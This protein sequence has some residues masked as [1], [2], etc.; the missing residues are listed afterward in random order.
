MQQMVSMARIIA[1]RVDDMVDDMDGLLAAVAA[2]SPP[3]GGQAQAYLDA[4]RPQLRGYIDDV[5]VWSPQGA[6]LAHVSRGEGEAF[7]DE[8]LLRSAIRTRALA[9]DG[10]LRNRRGD[11]VLGFARPVLDARGEI[12]AVVG[13]SVRAR[14]LRRIVDPSGILPAHALVGLVDHDGLVVARS[15]DQERFVGQYAPVESIRRNFVAREGAADDV[16][17][18]GVRRLY[19]FTTPSR[20][21]W[22]AYVGFDGAAALAPTWARLVTVLVPGT[23]A[24]L[25]GVLLAALVGTHIA[26]ALGTLAR[27]AQR[28]SRGEA[29]GVSSVDGKDEIAVLARTLD[30]MAASLRERTAAVAESRE[31]LSRVTANV[32]VLIAHID[33]RQRIRFANAYHRDVFG[34]APQRLLGRSLR[35]LFPSATYNR[36]EAQVAEV[37][38][39]DPASFETTLDTVSGSRWFLVSCFPDYGDDQAVTG[40]YVVCQDITRRREA[41]DALKQSDAARRE[42]ERRIRLI[43][44]N[45]PAAITYVNR[46]E[47]YLFCNAAFSA[48]FERSVADLI[49]CRVADVLTP[50]VYASTRPHIEAVLRGEH[51]RFQRL[52]TRRGTPRHELVEYIP[53][54][55][56]AGE[57]SGFFALIQ[58]ITD[59]HDAQAQVEASE[60]RLRGMTES[61]PSLLCYID[62]A[63][64]YR[65]NSRYYEEWMGLPLAQI[66]GRHVREVVGEA[67]F[68]VDEPAMRRALAG[69]RVEFEIAHTDAQGTRYVRGT[70]V[71][72]VGP[73]GTVAGIYGATTDI[74]SLKQVEQ[75]LARLAP[76]D[77]LTGLPNRNQ[78]DAR[79]AEALARARRGGLNVGLLFLDVDGFK[80]INDTFG[81][82]GGDVVLRE[83]GRRLAGAVRETDM[84]A[85]LAGDEFVVVLE[86][87]HR[88]DE[89]LFIARKIVAAMRRPFAVDAAHIDVTTSIGIALAE[90]DATPELLLQRADGALYRAKAQGRNR[91]EVA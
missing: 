17:V 73:D 61:V 79:I 59:L 18:D 41:E 46:H 88:R 85:R 31:R 3:A 84:V 74:T 86:G 60:R 33:A 11:N 37:L 53:E 52:A 71:P 23:A 34:V 6:M 62:P 80:R 58:D 82:G 35:A 42:S 83:F 57:A 26:G 14:E 51:Q 13:A 22:L 20:V 89:C 1:A 45:V 28:L 49:G 2:A 19:G 8:P 54:L 63:L 69:E 64:H 77:S 29:T 66:T 36:I 21:R 70:Y 55:D 40:F 44:D 24:L 39:G 48:A 5:A 15:A 75:E 67:T 68:G 56:A 27:D 81:H 16:G 91:Y 38:R 9:V 65:F 7:A 72:D 32:P 76:F 4:L 47:R 43:A 25:L 78:F 90:D 12:V 50:E 87:I 10:P 30:G